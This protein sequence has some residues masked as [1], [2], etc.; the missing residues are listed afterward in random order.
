MTA[1]KSSG[2][3]RGKKDLLRNLSPK[4]E[5]FARMR[6]DTK[7]LTEKTRPCDLVRGKGIMARSVIS[8]GNGVVGRPEKKRPVNNHQ[9]VRGKGMGHVRNHR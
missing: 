9:I 6:E 5:G 8:E 3:Q 7:G 4:L 2:P 1:E